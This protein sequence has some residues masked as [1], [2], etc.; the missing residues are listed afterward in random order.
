M[1]LNASGSC[2]WFRI[3][4]T[5]TIDGMSGTYTVSANGTAA[6]TTISFS[7]G[8]ASALAIGTVVRLTPN[9][10][11]FNTTANTGMPANGII[12]INGGAGQ[13]TAAT[14]AT[15]TAGVISIGA[16]YPANAIPIDSVVE[17]LVC[18][19]NTASP[20]VSVTAASMASGWPGAARFTFISQP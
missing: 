5:F 20:Q 11:S 16:V 17:R 13:I 12:R 8:L 18:W 6:S 15:V 9:T 1:S 19:T 4:D 10:A 7:P 2:T 3:G 14:S